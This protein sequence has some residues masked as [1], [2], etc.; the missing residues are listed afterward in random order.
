[1]IVSAL[2]T[3]DVAAGHD[4][5]FLRKTQVPVQLL[6]DPQAANWTHTRAQKQLQKSPP[7]SHLQP[8][9]TSPAC[10]PPLA[11]LLITLDCHSKY[12]L[13]VTLW[14]ASGHEAQE[15]Q[16]S[17]R[18]YFQERSCYAGLLHSAAASVCCSLAASWG[19]A[20]LN[21]L[22]LACYF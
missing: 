12:Q 5:T 3:R 19:H 17:A 2:P 7:H 1:M 6:S 4:I 18:R 22:S 10:K 9:P 8:R 13:H 16:V 14:V 20:K 11:S 15:H 21:S